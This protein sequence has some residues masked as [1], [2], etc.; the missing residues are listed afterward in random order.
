MVFQP[1]GVLDSGAA[2]KLGN[3][4]TA[5]FISNTRLGRI[6]QIK[7]SQ[8]LPFSRRLKAALSTG[9]LDVI[10]LPNLS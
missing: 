9:L 2:V 4:V 10:D 8:V 3:C 7:D 6:A 5:Y 1:L